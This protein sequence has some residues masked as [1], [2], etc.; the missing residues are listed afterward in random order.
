MSFHQKRRGVSDVIGVLLMLA[1]VVSLGVLVSA[2]ADGGMASFSQ[3][4]GNAMAGQKSA[5]SEKF[6]VEQE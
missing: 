3:G 6:N 2:F 5:L 4:Y 1:V